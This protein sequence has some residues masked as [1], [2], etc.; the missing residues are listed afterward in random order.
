MKRTIICLANSKK[1]GERCIAGIEV[2]RKPRGGWQIVKNEG[3]PKWLRP[4]S[5]SG[6]GEVKES[7]VKDIG[8]LNVVEFQAIRACGIGYQSENIL[9]KKGSLRQISLIGCTTK[10]LDVLVDKTC[11]N[12]FGDHDK[13]I[14]IS[15]IQKVN[16]SLVFVKV[17]RVQIYYP[18]VYKTMNP[19]AKITFRG[20][21][22]DLPVTDVNMI[23]KLY[24]N[25]NWLKD[26][27]NLYCTFSLG[28][29]FEGFHYKIA[30]GILG[31]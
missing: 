16:H 29:H 22:Y 17:E 28:V 23:F 15:D 31:F 14:S 24:E 21:N 30:A 8:L 1:Y 4:V 12:L 13:K 5:D 6:H 26:K 25:P 20:K 7:E 19:R 18:V 9:F 2:I 27:K 10:N 3:R 11:S